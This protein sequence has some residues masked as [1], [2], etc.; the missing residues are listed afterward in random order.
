MVQFRDL[1]IGKK[2]LIIIMGICI[3]TLLVSLAAFLTF[4]LVELRKEAVRELSTTARI[5]GRNC[6]AALIFNDPTDAA[7]N[8]AG[9]RSNPSVISAWIFTNEDRSFA[10]Y[11]REHAPKTLE[12]PRLRQ[13]GHFF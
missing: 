6:S 11:R 8:L 12:P 3:I 7:E 5:I 13:A 2:L 10:A 4:D 1:P 9:L